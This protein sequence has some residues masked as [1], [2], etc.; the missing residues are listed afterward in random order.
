[1]SQPSRKHKLGKWQLAMLGEIAANKICCHRSAIAL[2]RGEAAKW[3]RR[4]TRS[5]RNAINAHNNGLA[6]NSPVDP[7]MK[8]VEDNKAGYKLVPK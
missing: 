7:R 5:L 2:L 3:D 6:T 8:I 1:M 4:Y